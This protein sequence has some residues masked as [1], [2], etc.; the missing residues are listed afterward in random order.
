[1]TA[2][3]FLKVLGAKCIDWTDLDLEKDSNNPQTIKSSL[4]LFQRWINKAC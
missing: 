4:K 3:F 2:S 1:M